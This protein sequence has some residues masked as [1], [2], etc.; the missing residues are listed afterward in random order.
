M[1]TAAS[2][3]RA[4]PE[5]ESRGDARLNPRAVMAAHRATAR[6]QARPRRSTSSYSQL[7][8]CCPSENAWGGSVGGERYLA[9]LFE[10]RA[11]ATAHDAV[12]GLTRGAGH[13]ATTRADPVDGSDHQ[14]ARAHRAPPVTRHAPSR[15]RNDL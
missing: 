15:A 13:L 6:A 1:P 3:S 2:G 11:V 8:P 14:L 9:L 5:P 4:V 10:A 7:S 12:L